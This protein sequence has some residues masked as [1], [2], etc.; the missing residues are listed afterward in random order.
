MS[1]LS[2][3]VDSLNEPL[4]LKLGRGQVPQSGEM[5]PHKVC[6]PQ[7]V[8]LQVARLSRSLPHGGTLNAYARQAVH[9]CKGTSACFAADFVR[10]AAL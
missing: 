9:D 3:R 1:S 6:A 7:A 5:H 10:F 2:R 8:R 4:A